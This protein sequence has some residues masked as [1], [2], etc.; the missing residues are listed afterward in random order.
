MGE[1][2]AAAG[3][4]RGEEGAHQR[5]NMVQG[6]EGKGAG[7]FVENGH[8]VADGFQIHLEVLK[9]QHD[10]FGRAGGAGGVEDRGQFMRGAGFERGAGGRGDGKG[11]KSSA[12]NSARGRLLGAGLEGGG[13]DRMRFGG[14]K[15]TAGSVCSKM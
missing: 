3:V 15:M 7:I 12:S 14:Q 11:R 5:Q 2:D 1:D 6:Q 13:Y 4:K 10:T 9:G 8:T